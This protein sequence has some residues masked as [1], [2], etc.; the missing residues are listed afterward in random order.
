MTRGKPLS[1]EAEP[2]ETSVLA[3]SRAEGKVTLLRGLHP[4]VDRAAL[5]AP[6]G[7]E[8][9]PRGLRGLGRE[10]PGGGGAGRGGD[11]RLRSL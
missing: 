9:P 6:A 11:G 5:R 1:A 10:L 2:L 7:Q 3:G 4:A 8:D